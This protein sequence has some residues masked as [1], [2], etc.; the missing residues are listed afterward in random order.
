MEGIP[1]ENGPDEVPVDD[2]NPEPDSDEEVPE[3]QDWQPEA[4]QPIDLKLA[5]D[6]SGRPNNRDFARLLRRGNAKPEVAR[7][8]LKFLK[9]DECEAHKI[10]YDRRP[11]AAPKSYRVNHVVGIDPVEVNPLLMDYN[12]FACIS[13]AGDLPFN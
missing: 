9:C 4:E 11:A 13:Y 5:H 1:E 6:S 12:T 7:W 8:V 3:K 2:P 10:P